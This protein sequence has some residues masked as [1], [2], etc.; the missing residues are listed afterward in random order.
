MSN[1]INVEYLVNQFKEIREQTV[2]LA[3]QQGLEPCVPRLQVEAPDMLAL[4]QAIDPTLLK[5]VYARAGKQAG[6]N[7]D[8]LYVYAYFGLPD[9]EDDLVVLYAKE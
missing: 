9:S 6:T 1:R 2:K 8:R 7:Q 5:R 3:E 4:V